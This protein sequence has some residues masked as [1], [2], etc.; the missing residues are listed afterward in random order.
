MQ[1]LRHEEWKPK[2]GG[3]AEGEGSKTENSE[4][5]KCVC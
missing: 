4:R 1:I 5:E 2:G 3:R